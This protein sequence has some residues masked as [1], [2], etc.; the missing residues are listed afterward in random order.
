MKYEFVKKGEPVF[1]IGKKQIIVADQFF[2][3]YFL[4]MCHEN[5]YSWS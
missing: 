3:T 1:H 2:L 5:R 4:L